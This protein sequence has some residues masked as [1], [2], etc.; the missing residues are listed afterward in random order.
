MCQ[1]K[2]RSL[3]KSALAPQKGQA[4][5][6]IYYVRARQTPLAYTVALGNVKRR[7]PAKPLTP[8]FPRI[9]HGVPLHVSPFSTYNIYFSTYS[10]VHNIMRPTNQKWWH[11]KKA[12]FGHL[13]YGITKG[14]ARTR[15]MS[16][17]WILCLASQRNTKN[18]VPS[19]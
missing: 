6:V 9:H 14:D 3:Y 8:V 12:S 11:N 4:G 18:K 16:T 17:C 5:S 19:C 2:R 15:R 13:K 7:S 10:V 1:Q